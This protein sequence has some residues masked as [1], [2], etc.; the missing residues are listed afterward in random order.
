M[1][2]NNNIKCNFHNQDYK[3]Y[4]KECKDCI[5][6]ECLDTDLHQMH[7]FCK[8]KVAKND[9]LKELQ[10]FI[11][12]NS[13]HN[14]ETADHFSEALKRKIEEFKDNELLMKTQVIA[15]AEE[16]IQHI[17]AS[18][19]ELLTSLEKHFHKYNEHIKTVQDSLK[20]ICTNVNDL[21]PDT[22]K[23][24]QAVNLLVEMRRCI[25]TCKN[26]LSNDE[27]PT[28]IHNPN[29]ACECRVQTDN[30]DNFVAIEHEA[31]Q[32]ES[33]SDE[34][35][36]DYPRTISF[37]NEKGLIDK[38]IPISDQDAWVIISRQLRKIKNRVLESTIYERA[39][40]FVVLNDG[41]VVVFHYWNKFIKRLL[42]DG[43][44]VPFSCLNNCTDGSLCLTE[45]SVFINTSCFDQ[46]NSKTLFQ[47]MNSFDFN[48]IISSTRNLFAFHLMGSPKLAVYIKGKVTSFCILGKYSVGN[49]TL[50]TIYLVSPKEKDNDSTNWADV[51][52]FQGTF[53]MSPS[54]EFKCNGVCIDKNNTIVVSDTTYK[55]VYAL[56]ENMKFKKF[57]ISNSDYN[58]ESP[59]AIAIY[60]NLLWVA[61]GKKILIFRY[62][63]DEVK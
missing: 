24:Y 22:I 33:S 27:K 51:K 34:I 4:C 23:D 10:T 36:E 57:I 1:A 31:N 63:V 19:D 28:F 16:M 20:S 47:Y 14:S 56:D 38:I 8:F 21:D 18:E 9:I 35:K 12:N 25:S 50:S 15:G 53:G 61:D 40:D 32:E 52:S 26:L 49:N 41:S 6:M 3:L 11:A 37:D 58:L 29:C 60:N 13:E 5:C 59:G 45:N 55:C 48:G 46:G 62:N 54:V 39:D 7:S 42:L 43:R 2:D 17:K 44:V 30:N